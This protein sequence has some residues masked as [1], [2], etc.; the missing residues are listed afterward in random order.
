MQRLG[1]DSKSEDSYGVEN[2]GA[3]HGSSLDRQGRKQY[4]QTEI[5]SLV[6]KDVGH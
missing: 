6:D 1:E 3:I 5:N 2:A 4:K